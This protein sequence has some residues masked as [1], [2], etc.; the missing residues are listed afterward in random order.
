MGK[1]TKVAAQIPVLAGDLVVGYLE[2][3]LEDTSE[4]VWPARESYNYAK[5]DV[6]ANLVISIDAQYALFNGLLKGVDYQIEFTKVP[7]E[8]SDG[9][10][11]V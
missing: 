8:D 11:D 4:K 1:V 2:V 6:G 5:F 7:V 3:E 10:T 9:K